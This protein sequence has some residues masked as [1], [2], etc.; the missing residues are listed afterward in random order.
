MAVHA[1]DLLK[2]VAITFITSTV[3]LVSGQSTEREH[4]PANQQK[5][6]LKVTEHNPPIRTRPSFPHSQSLPSGRLHKP[7]ILS[8]RGETE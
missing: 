3:A 6:G 5:I 2:E 4:S 8:L 7:F 1:R